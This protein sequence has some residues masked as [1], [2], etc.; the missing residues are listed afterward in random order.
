MHFSANCQKPF[1]LASLLILLWLTPLQADDWPQW[2]GPTRDN[3]WHEDGIVEAFP[4]GG[5]ERLW[6]AEV[7][8]GYAGPAVAQGRVF[9]TDYVPTDAAAPTTN[10]PDTITGRE[11]VHCLDADTGRQLWQH[12][13]PVGYTISYPAGPRCT[14]LIEEDR[15]YVLGAE[16]HLYCLSVETGDVVWSKHLREAYHTTTATWGYASH[17]LIDGERLI[18]IAGTDQ[19]HAVALNKHTGEELWRAGTAPEQGYCPPVIIE[20][21]GVR[22]LIL[23]K[24]DGMYAVVPETGELLWETPYNADNGSIIMQPVKIGD[25]LYIG[26]FQE[27]NL[28]LKLTST[29]PGVEVV[30]RN[31]RQHGISAVNVQPFVLDGHLCGFHEKGDLRMVAIPSGEVV[32]SSGGP[33]PGRLGGCGTA[34][35]TRHNDRF[36]LFTETGDLVIAELRP[37][38]YTERDRAHLI[39]PSNTAFGRDV[40]WSTP[41][42]AEQSV[43]VRN[44]REIVRYSLAARPQ[45]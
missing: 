33:L 27:K 16:G 21:A 6:K 1:G 41:A 20:A 19:A 13:W 42:F 32:L 11:R 35:F 39:D 31:K 29:S 25:Y 8:G 38:G 30:W 44:D 14:P 37:S 18:C 2:M 23:M 10:N 24:P 15:V 7:A 9:V 43:F 22:Q 5:P 26:G 12:T 45:Q 4:K 17:P 36:F 40:V 34:F 28:L 3:V